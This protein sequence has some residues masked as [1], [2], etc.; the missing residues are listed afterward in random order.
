MNKKNIG[1][2][3]KTPDEWME[4]WDRYISGKMDDNEE[5]LKEL[6]VHYTLK[7]LEHYDKER[8]GKIALDFACGDGTNSC[9][10]AKIGYEVE[11]FDA[12]TSA[13]E[14]TKKRA[15]ILGVEEK[16]KVELGNMENW[17]IKKDYYDVIVAMQSL[18]YLFEGTREKLKELL[19]A[20]KEEGIIIY[21]GN[22]KPHFPTN[23]SLKFITKKE[24][25][26]MLENWECLIIG[27]DEKVIKTGDK[28]GYV[29]VMAKKHK[30][31]NRGKRK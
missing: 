5:K 2:N 10:L 28:R 20:L 30:G 18:Q 17:E 7:A 23:P 9:Y 22:V 26:K 16:V 6:N 15:K 14:I 21:S 3:V 25:E 13:V 31:K 29:W 19:V 12:L 1:L 8:D 27:Q 4:G 11:A 24:L